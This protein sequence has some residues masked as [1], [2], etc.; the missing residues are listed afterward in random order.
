MCQTCAESSAN[1]FR[2]ALGFEQAA[3]T[4]A[5]ILP[6]VP[7][8]CSILAVLQTYTVYKSQ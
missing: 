1:V 2:S 3:V 5:E 8:N 6:S 7:L 4:F